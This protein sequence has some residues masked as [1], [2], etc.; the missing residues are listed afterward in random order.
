MQW[1]VQENIF[2]E[3][4][5]GRLIETLERF[6]VP[7]TV[8]KVIPFGGGIIPD[9][10][11]TGPTMVMGA[12]TMWKV[13]AEKQWVPGSFINENFDYIVQHEHWGDLMFN[14]DSW[15]GRFDSVPEQTEE[16]FI[17]PIHDTKSFNGQTI[18]WENF[19]SWQQD[20]LKVGETSYCTINPDTIV[21]VATLKHIYCEYRLWVVDGKIVTASLYKRGD[22]VYTD[23]EVDD[24]IIDFGYRCI[25][26]WVPARAFC[27]DI[28]VGP[29]GPLIGEVNNINAAGFYKADV[30]KLVLALNEMEF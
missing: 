19:K 24:E 1:V 29:N 22:R 18:D 21:Q 14:H 27:L 4:G 12:Y 17:R 20:I 11:F 5:Y 10:D 8:V 13:A 26:T 7:Y 30:Q 23:E 9:V 3:Y 15:V 28:F 16:F 6:D 2:N 25:N